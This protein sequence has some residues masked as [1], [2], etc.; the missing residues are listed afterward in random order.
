MDNLLDLKGQKSLITK[1][2]K[3][4]RDFI[5]SLLDDKSFVET[6]AFLFTKN[7]LGREEAVGGGV[8]TGYGT[9]SGNPVYI[10]CQ[11]YD[12][13][14]GGI[15]D[16][17]ARKIMKCMAAAAAAGVPLISV[18]HTAGAKVG[19]G[20]TAMNGF[21]EIISAACELKGIIPQISVIKGECFG[22][23]SYLA[24]VSDFIYMLPEA[25]LLTAAP[26]VIAAKSGNMLSAKELGGSKV[27]AE[28]SGLC[29]FEVKNA[30]ELKTG[31]A[32]L[33][34]YIQVED[35]G[36][37][38][39]AELNRQV[40][41][42]AK[43]D[44]RKLVSEVFDASSVTEISKDYQPSL[45]TAFA[46]LGG[47]TVGVIADSGECGSLNLKAVMKATKFVKILDNFGLPLI[48]LVNNEGIESCMSCE[49]EGLAGEV[50]R[51]MYAISQSDSSKISVICKNAI[52]AG[53]TALA[54]KSMGFD[55]SLAWENAVI[56]P[57]P[58]SVGAELFYSEEIK[59]SKNN[60]KIR[61][62]VEKQYGEELAS[63][64]TAAMNGCIDNIISPSSTRQYLISAL[65]MLE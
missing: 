37:V 16:T 58:A 32:K 52:G 33:L 53:Y 39:D 17:A 49:Q 62:A 12:A 41:V 21:S 60:E 20:I 8:V 65:M 63:P 10:Y 35:A 45:I 11:N 50:A 61:A 30:Q 14:K 28:K 25:S 6:D 57:V 27:H 48:T 24:S 4:A 29:S 5:L 46:R 18:L 13:A 51:L 31:I 56:S 47:R 1:N 22:H 40:K 44:G 23:M 3:P 64:V 38:S 26:Q 9:L 55:Y 7:D 54:G 15:G 36:T 59:A 43:Y 34:D 19:E 42:A 2:S